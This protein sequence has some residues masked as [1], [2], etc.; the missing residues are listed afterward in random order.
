M[1]YLTIKQALILLLA[2]IPGLLFAQ[3]QQA[4]STMWEPDGPVFSI[5]ANESTVYIGGA[6]NYVGPNSGTGVSFNKASSRMPASFPKVKGTIYKVVSDGTGGWYISGSFTRIGNTA[7]SYLARLNQDLTL[8]TNFRPEPNNDIGCML[9][10]EGVLYVSGSFNQVGGEPRDYIAALDPETGIATP[11]AP[12]AD[13]SVNCMA[14]KDTLLYVGG[15]FNNI[16]GKPRRAL[17]ALSTITGK[18]NALDAE[19]LSTNTTD[20]PF[21]NSLVLGGDKIYI[22]GNGFTE[23]GGL[24]RVAV[25]SLYINSFRASDWA[26][27]INDGDNTFAYV[28]SIALADTLV[29]IGGSFNKAGNTACSGLA[30]INASSG[31]ID[32][33][34]SLLDLDNSATGGN[35]TNIFQLLLDDS[36]LYIA[37]YFQKIHNTDRANLCAINI[38]TGRLMPFS[39]AVGNLVLCIASYGTDL[40]AGG[41][42]SSANGVMRKG[43]AALNIATGS[44]TGWAPNLSSDIYPYSNVALMKLI[45]TTLYISGTFSKI[46]NIQTGNIVS[47]STVTGDVLLAF[48]TGIDYLNALTVTGESFYMAGP[49]TWFSRQALT[50]SFNAQTGVYNRWASFFNSSSATPVVNALAESRGK[51][52]IGGKFD[53]AGGT[54]V[55]N[56]AIFDSASGL[57][58]PISSRFNINSS[59]G[60]IVLAESP[61]RLIVSGDFDSAAGQ[62]RKHIAA[63]NK[64]TGALSAWNPGLTSGQN[65]YVSVKAIALKGNTGYVVGSFDNAGGRARTSLAALDLN[66]NTALPWYINLKEDGYGNS[67]VMN[68][69][70]NSNKVF[71]GGFFR[72][73]GE[74]SRNY[75]AA[76]PAAQPVTGIT[77]GNL[78]TSSAF[79]LYPNPASTELRISNLPTNTT[80]QIFNLLGQVAL[81][82]TYNGNSLEINTL[83]PG[84]YCVAVTGRGRKYFVKE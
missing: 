55:R 2:F 18:A 68:V 74:R 5:Q 76:L 81:S 84:L 59:F 8:N 38:K 44:L 52:Y 9:L 47:L 29:Y 1:K 62:P 6:F 4:D 66:S 28:A 31:E 58:N 11:W 49:Y 69:C 16:G 64:T 73:T 40:Y 19:A 67:L 37:G 54:A 70:L 23:I 79:T 41:Y 32:L 24:P 75:F 14:I 53:S 10:N 3:E 39:P 13:R 48:D 65:G 42:F 46:G 57:L 83:Q 43:L 82:Y 17:A 51:L 25:A 35:G 22:G 77:E 27:L 33:Q 72:V 36:T 78:P 60:D 30:V 50:A 21:I 45:G 20:Q 26:P 12:A 15:R 34:T 61:D 63:F 80:V 56:I 71:I 7:I